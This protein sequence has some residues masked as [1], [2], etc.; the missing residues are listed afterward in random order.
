MINFYPR[1]VV[2]LFCIIVS[3]AGKSVEDKGILSTKHSIGI[4]V[5]G[6]AIG[7]LLYRKFFENRLGLQTSIL[8]F[9]YSNSW[10]AFFG[11]HLFFAINESP[12]RYRFYL[13]GG[14]S[15]ILE[16]FHRTSILPGAGFGMEIGLTRN[17]S[18]ATELFVAPYIKI[19]R[20]QTALGY[21]PLPIIGIALLYHFGK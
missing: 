16:A 19:G 18:L 20:P 6:P 14:V 15:A 21:I 3:P 17:F 2:F 12:E 1:I 8:A 9:P 5:G 11:G 7:G 13:L 4:S 10:D